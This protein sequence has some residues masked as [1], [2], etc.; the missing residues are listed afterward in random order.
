MYPAQRFSLVA[1]WVRGFWCAAKCPP[2]DRRTFESSWSGTALRC[3]EPLLAVLG[4]DLWM[5]RDGKGWDGMD[6][7]MHLPIWLSVSLCIYVYHCV[8]TYIHLVCIRHT[9]KNLMDLFTDGMN[10]LPISCGWT[11]RLGKKR[12]Q[13]EHM[14]TDMVKHMEWFKHIWVMESKHF[15]GYMYPL[16]I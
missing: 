1:P 14:P 8:S 11:I 7:W 3:W 9:S 13:Q 6:G 12:P 5:G 10:F 2:T 4:V 15:Q 16:V